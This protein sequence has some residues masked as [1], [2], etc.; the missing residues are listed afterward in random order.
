MKRPI[1]IR[2]AGMEESSALTAAAH[3]RAHG[4]AWDYSEI[5]AC[6]V[7]IRRDPEEATP[8]PRYSVRVD[9]T[10]PGHELVAKTIR[11]VDVLSAMGIAFEDMTLQLEGIDPRVNHAEYATTSPGVLFAPGDIAGEKR[12]GDRRSEE[13]RTPR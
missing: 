6:W 13:R 3:G 2:F 5:I 7:G 9:V 11:N 4:L 12:Y 1:R 8:G 10:V